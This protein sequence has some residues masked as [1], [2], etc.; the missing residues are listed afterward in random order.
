MKNVCSYCI[1]ISISPKLCCKG[2]LPATASFKLLFSRL[3]PRGGQQCNFPQPSAETSWCILCT[4]SCCPYYPRG[5]IMVRKSPCRSAEYWKGQYTV[6]REKQQ[7]RACNIGKKYPR[8]FHSLKTNLRHYSAREMLVLQGKGQWCKGN[9]SLAV[10]PWWWDL[11]GPLVLW[12][13]CQNL[14]LL[15]HNHPKS[16]IQ[17]PS[18][19]PSILLIHRTIP[20]GQTGLLS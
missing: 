10:E 15:G 4:A 18:L 2:P 7:S 1:R 16:W 8:W 3:E 12:A 14:L 11:F 17:Q 5:W 19:H 20:T 13:T 9:A 6:G